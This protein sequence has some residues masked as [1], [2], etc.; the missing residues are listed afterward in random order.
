MNA[1]ADSGFLNRRGVGVV[2]LLH[3]ICLEWVNHLEQ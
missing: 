3:A 1:M 2:V